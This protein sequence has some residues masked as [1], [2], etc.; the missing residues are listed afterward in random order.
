MQCLGS[1]SPL[2]RPPEA[3]QPSGGSLAAVRTWLQI[4]GGSFR[5]LRDPDSK[6]SV[7][8]LS[9]PPGCGLWF[10][11]QAVGSHVRGVPGRGVGFD[12]QRTDPGDDGPV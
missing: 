1:P 11:A 6:A 12:R 8:V 5:G 3:V 2:A 9:R 10:E 7:N 4:A